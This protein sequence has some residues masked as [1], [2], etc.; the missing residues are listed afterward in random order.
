MLRQ[1]HRR[2][3]VVWLRIK[4]PNLPLYFSYLRACFM[5]GRNFVHKAN[6]QLIIN[7]ILLVD[8]LLR[9]VGK[10]RGILVHVDGIKS[11]RGIEFIVLLIPNIAT[12]WRSVSSSH[13]IHFTP[14]KE[15]LYHCTEDCIGSR[16]ALH[17]FLRRE[18]IFFLLRLETPAVEPV[19]IRY[20]EEA[21]LLPVKGCVTLSNK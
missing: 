21:N 19:V 9:T 6:S 11:C 3:N 2:P 14:R 15:H 17:R 10:R 18:D 5:S 4:K 12:Y 13:R 8:C 7:F 1:R 16:A 20:T